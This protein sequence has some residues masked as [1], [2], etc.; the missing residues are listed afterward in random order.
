[1]IWIWIALTLLQRPWWSRT[2]PWRQRFPPKFGGRLTS[3]PL[4]SGPGLPICPIYVSIY[5]GIYFRSLRAFWHIRVID[6]W[7][8]ALTHVKYVYSYYFR[9]L[10]EGT[11]FGYRY[12]ETGDRPQIYI[13]SFLLFHISVSVLSFRQF[14]CNPYIYKLITLI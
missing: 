2:K 9:G 12:G 5:I 6:R 4:T 11:Y 13:C 10:G 8:T 1:V 3:G 14:F 7:L